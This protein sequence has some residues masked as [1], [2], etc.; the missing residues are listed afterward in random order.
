MSGTQFFQRQDTQRKYT[1]ILV[2]G[3]IAAMLLVI[4]VINLIVIVGFGVPPSELVE[5][6]GILFGISGVVGAI[7]LCSSLYKFSQLRA[8]GAAVAR[9]LGGVPV[10]ANDGDLKRQRLVNVV[11]EMAIAAR[12]R[13]PQVF[14]LPDEEAINAFAAGHSPDEAAVAVTQGAL[15]AFDREQ[16]QAVVGHEFSHI[17]NGDM[18]LNMRLAAW[19]FGLWVITDIALRMLRGRSRGK[20]AA[21]LKLIA[22]GIWAAGSVGM[23]AGR[24]LQAAISRRREH[25]AD[26]SAVQFTRNPGALQSAFVAMA[27]NHAGTRLEH[28]AAAGVAHMFIAS[29]EP[30]WASK[31]GSFFATHPTLEERVRALDSRVTPSRFKSLVSE[32]RR[33]LVAKQLAEEAAAAGEPPPPPQAP[34]EKGALGMTSPVIAGVVLAAAAAESAAAAKPAGADAGTTAPAPASV[35]ASASSI[36][37]GGLS[38]ADTMTSGVRKLAGRVLPPDVL[39]DRLSEDQQHAIVS[40]LGQI[41]GSPEAVQGAFV[42]TMLA[43][44]PAKWRMQLT[45]LAPLLGIELMKE[46]QAQIARIAQLAPASKLPFLIDLLPLLENMDP[47]QRKRLRAVARAFAPTV[48]TGDMLRHAVTRLLEKKLVKTPEKAPQKAEDTL[49]PV[50]LPERA[51]AVCALYAALARC[52]FPAGNQGQNAYRAGLM[53]LLPPPKWAS[54]PEALAAPAQLDAAIAGVA[55]IHP[56][57]KR[58][59]AEGMVRVISVGGALTVPQVDL[60]RATCLLVDCPVPVLPPD[61]VYE[62]SDVARTSQAN[63]R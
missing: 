24:M 59:F 1:R 17:L 61:V 29:S 32:E 63:A 16:L 20:D 34:L 7:I 35:T 40:Y 62:D 37:L 53:G 36:R 46:T 15:D 47:A 58:A 19:V 45:K 21:R 6:P 12:I 39:R 27:A 8:G 9:A 44:E 3:F 55:Q 60:L 26:A 10:T 49:P 5:N 54:Y 25:L 51:E 30:S 18:K 14:V 41:E 33:R 42:A 38:L 57:G 50:P 48:A 52:R 23:V 43:S 56:T 31:F 13:K 28:A 22:L 2:G 4:F 11:E